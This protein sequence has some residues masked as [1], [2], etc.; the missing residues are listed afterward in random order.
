MGD[1]PQIEKLAGA[2]I[3]YLSK[4]S[5]YIFDLS[6]GQVGEADI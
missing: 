3:I 1:D 6:G 4:R 2:V 5:K